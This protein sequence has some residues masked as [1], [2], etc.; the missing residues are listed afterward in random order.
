MC[1]LARIS[2]P[3]DRSTEYLTAPVPFSSE[4]SRWAQHLGLLNPPPEASCT[5]LIHTHHTHLAVLTLP[6]DARA[7][8]RNRCTFL[9][10]PSHQPSS[11]K[12][13]SLVVRL[14]IAQV[15][16]WTEGMKT[17]SAV[18]TWR[19]ICWAR[20]QVVQDVLP[21]EQGS[22]QT[23]RPAVIPC[24]NVCSIVYSLAL[25][26]QIQYCAHCEGRTVTPLLSPPNKPRQEPRCRW[27]PSSPFSQVKPK[28]GQACC[29]A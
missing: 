26:V 12:H 5:K 3:T 17:T 10:S 18:P 16:W 14:S 13:L 1:L 27:I 7:L 23:R 20:Q 4:Y 8:T 24:T 29:R 15:N 21:A 9:R 6:L 28:K 19:A 11:C 22:D 25:N 2:I